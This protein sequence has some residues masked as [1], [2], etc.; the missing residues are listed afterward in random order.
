MPNSLNNALNNID[1]S[2]LGMSMN[3]APSGG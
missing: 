3:G 1:L 2:S